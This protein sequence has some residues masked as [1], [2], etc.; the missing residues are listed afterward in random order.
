[1]NVP[2]AFSRMAR[3]MHADV[4]LVV[5]SDDE[6]T[7]YLARSLTA[8]EKNIVS[9]F[10]ERL[11]AA[12]LNDEGLVKIWSETGSDCYLRKGY[13]ELFYRDLLAALRAQ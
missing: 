4:E 6:L 11:L 5:R 13:A 2:S 8:Q 7:A 10:I 3:H 12:G 1:M 9:G